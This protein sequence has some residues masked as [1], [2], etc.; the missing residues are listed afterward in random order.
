MRGNKVIGII[1]III[2]VCLTVFLV[3]KLTSSSNSFVNIHADK[4]EFDGTKAN[5]TE[6][7]EFDKNSFNMADIELHSESLYVQKSTDDKVHVEVY[8]PEAYKPTVQVFQNTLK[9]TPCNKKINII[10][11]INRRV[12][13]KLPE[14]MDITDFDADVTSGS[15]HI[16]NIN[17]ETI[18]AKST[19]GSVHID[20][21]TFGNAELKSSSG[22]V[23][24]NE[25]KIESLEGKSSSGSVKAKGNFSKIELTSISGSIH[26][27]SY[28]K[29]SGDSELR[30]T[31]GSI[32]LKIPSDS[33]FNSKY[34]CVSGTYHNDITGT[35]GKKGNETV[36]GGGPKIE[37][38]STSGSIHIN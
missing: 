38:H 15:I 30:S 36:N 37:L 26:A 22:S 3:W 18:D 21:C 29:L 4:I 34:S 10:G 16:E 7:F 14:G 27:E 11:L 20:Y 19:S 24:I 8:A 2:A 6:T 28:N 32:Y 5:I 12:I 31:S 35:S 23:N 1:W 17:L 13:V 25:S 9:I 33:N